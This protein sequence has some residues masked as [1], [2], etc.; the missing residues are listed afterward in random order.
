MIQGL[1]TTGEAQWAPPDTRDFDSFFRAIY[2]RLVRAV[3]LLTGE[4]HEAEDISQEAMARVLERWDRVRSM[5]SPEGYVYR[6]ALNLHRKRFRS[7]ARRQRRRVVL[8][9][10]SADH[11]EDVVVSRDVLH[12]VKSLPPTQREAL[13]LVG[14]LGY[15]SEEA[16]TVLGI[17][18]DSVRGRVHRAR[19]S[20]RA[21]G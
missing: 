1:E 9:V 20:P 15:S 16:G 11:A 10:P 6:T 18:P 14:W 12:A 13:V 4:I 7:L 2:P 8:P 17:G 21:G 5:E 19:A 3:L